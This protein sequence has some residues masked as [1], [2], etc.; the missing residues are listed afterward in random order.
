MFFPVMAAR[1]TQ[2]MCAWMFIQ[3]Y[4]LGGD[5]QTCSQDDFSV[6]YNGQNYFT[7]SSRNNTCMCNAFQSAAGGTSRFYGDLA[8]NGAFAA[9]AGITVPNG[10]SVNLGTSSLIAGTATFSGALTAN[11]GITVPNGQT[12]NLGTSSL[13][14]GTSTFSGLLTANNG[15]TVSGLLTAISGIAVSGSLSF[16]GSAALRSGCPSGWTAFGGFCYIYKG[17]NS[18]HTA[19]G[20][21]AN[22]YGADVCNVGQYYQFGPAICQSGTGTRCWTN[23]FLTATTAVAVQYGCCWDSFDYGN[24]FHYF[25]CLN[26][27]YY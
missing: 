6:T 21:C 27:L 9:N 4:S 23:S 22:S 14:A 15:L 24:A 10:Q 1:R 16:S 13:A 19:Q 25:C 8:V 2:L 7:V 12:V 3:L 5:A 17:T 26:R 20:N 11:A 18:A